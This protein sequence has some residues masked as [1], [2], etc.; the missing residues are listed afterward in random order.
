MDIALQSSV[1]VTSPEFSGWLLKRGFHVRNFYFTAFSSIDSM[2]S[3]E[4]YGRSVG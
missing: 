1:W 3:G 2:H 4:N